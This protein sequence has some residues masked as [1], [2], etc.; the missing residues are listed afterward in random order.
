MKRIIPLPIQIVDMGGNG[1]DGEAGIIATRL[2]LTA[3]APHAGK[4]GWR[5]AQGIE[6]TSGHACWLGHR[7][8]HAGGGGLIP[9]HPVHL[10]ILGTCLAQAVHAGA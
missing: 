4:D 7:A 2:L 5:T 3:N 10:H 9:P 8:K 6:V 1:I